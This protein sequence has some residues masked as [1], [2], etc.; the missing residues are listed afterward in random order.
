MQPSLPVTVDGLSDPTEFPDRPNM[1]GGAGVF[2]TNSLSQYESAPLQS[3]AHPSSRANG[4]SKRSALDNPVIQPAVAHRDKNTS[5][6]VSSSRGSIAMNAGV[7]RRK[8]EPEMKR[9]LERQV[10]PHVHAAVHPYRGT[11]THAELTKIGQTAVSKLVTVLDLMA[12]YMENNKTIT[13]AFESEV[14]L[15]ACL[16]VGQGVEK[17]VKQSLLE[18]D[19]NSAAGQTSPSQDSAVASCRSGLKSSA[20]TSENGLSTPSED[21]EQ[22]SKKRCRAIS[23]STLTSYSNDHTDAETSKQ[24]AS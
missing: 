19:A 1:L 16:F 13:P 18:E 6:A 15:N 20:E 2:R 22:T 21:F 23:V 5:L 17:V 3:S 8:L 7:K 12:H 24:N 11:V 4:V 9:V 14:K 10:L